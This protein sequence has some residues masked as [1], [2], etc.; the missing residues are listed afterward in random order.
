MSHIG[1]MAVF[2]RE[3]LSINTWRA[4]PGCAEL[5]RC[6]DTELCF[7]SMYRSLFSRLQ[8]GRAAT[9]IDITAWGPHDGDESSHITMRGPER[10]FQNRY[11]KPKFK[12]IGTYRFSLQF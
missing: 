4:L 5:S 1:N 8:A 3:L 7:D 2:A 9:S 12:N 10:I 11:I 6:L